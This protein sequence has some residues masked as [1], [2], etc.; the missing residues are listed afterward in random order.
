MDDPEDNHRANDQFQK[1]V[2]LDYFHDAAVQEVTTPIRGR[3]RHFYACQA[4]YPGTLVWFDP[5]DPTKFNNIG[6]FPSSAF[7]QGATFVGDQEWVCDTNGNIYKDINNNPDDPEWEFVGNSQTGGLVSLAYN[8]KDKILYGMSTSSFYW[9]DQDTG[10]GNLIGSLG[11]SSLMI[12]C[13]ANVDGV[14]YSYDLGFGTANTYTINLETGKA[15]VV[16]PTTVYLNYG[17]DMAYDF[18][19]D[20]LLATI[21]NYNTFSAEYHLIDQ[22][23]GK[24]TYIDGPL[25]GQTTCFA[26][27][28]GGFGIDVY[29]AP[30]NQNIGAIVANVGTFPERDMTCYAS[31]DEFI[32]DCENATN[33]YEDMIEDID[34]LE[35]LTGT[36]SLS[37]NDYLFAEEGPYV[38]TFELVDEGEDS[39]KLKNN[40]MEWG[41]GV[42]D[43]APT[44]SHELAIPAPNGENG[45]YVSDL[46][47]SV[48]AFDHTIGCETDGS[49]VKEIKYTISNDAG[50]T[51]TGDSGTFTITKDGNN[52]V[53]E[54]WAIDWVGNVESKNSFTIDMDQTLC[55]IDADG[56]HW[57][58]FQDG[59]FGDW[60][61]RFWTNATDAT[62]GMDRVEMYINEGLIEINT[63]PDGARYEFV[64]MWST[65]LETVTF[66]WRHYDRVGWDTYDE[67]Q[68]DEPSSKSY[69]SETR[70][71][72][73]K[74]ITLLKNL[75]MKR[76]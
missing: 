17:Q 45:Y 22:E 38:L 10:K 48:S 7:P 73:Q 55:E 43:T 53:V 47:V 62:S 31:I 28:G 74:Q 57:E 1:G 56:V 67:I 15:T 13:A 21:F 59:L 61:V 30:G 69:S 76:D 33:V 2:T 8:L 66:S 75:S 16:G 34:I 72:S 46:N 70:K 4:G 71:S 20:Q 29:V 37:F 49:G 36:K 12:S 60:Y 9:I 5:E 65:V 24:F 3:Q 68:G 11:V 39:D 6:T 64:I 50:G 25:P 41:I 44:S 40:V 63:S 26:I 32:T 58:A 35:P 19:E 18:E 14:M 52:I 27:P 42:D 23:T 54:Y 51:I